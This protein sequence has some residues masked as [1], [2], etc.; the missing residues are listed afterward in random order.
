MKAMVL[1]KPKPIDE[2]PLQE[3]DVPKPIVKAG[4]ILIRVNVCGVCHTDLH[5]V[6]GDLHLPMLPII[7]G[8]QVV[9]KV[10]ATGADVVKFKLGDRVGVPWL[11]STCGHC[12]YCRHNRENLCDH[13]RFTGW[14]VNG[15]YAEYMTAPDEFALRLP[16]EFPDLQAAPLLCAGIIG[17]RALKLS[18][19]R[20][21]QRLGLYGF[22]AS[23]H[24]TIQVALHWGCEVYVFSRSAGHREHAAELGAVWTGLAS[25]RLSNPLD[26]AIIFAPA[27]DLVLDA[28]GTLRKGGTLALAGIHMS[29]IPQMDY[30]L[31]YGERTIRSVANSTRRDAEELLLL[32]A[33]IPIRTEVEKY[34]LTQA[35]EVLRRLKQGEIRGA[36]VLEVNPPPELRGN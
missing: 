8:H 14:Q 21:G 15:G 7:P 29:P 10:E 23:A 20:P 33:E 2:N 31:I 35:N 18:E 22:G 24:V 13:G 11:H 26:S 27:G 36:A 9:G 25:D 6:E 32:A 34:S 17:Y 19:I 12:E 4:H 30:G 3:E 16:K 28:L 1:R 5:I